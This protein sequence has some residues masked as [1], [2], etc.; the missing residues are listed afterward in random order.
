[1]KDFFYA[2]S[3]FGFGYSLFFHLSYW[4]AY[5]YGFEYYVVYHGLGGVAFLVGWLVL[6]F[7]KKSRISKVLSLLSFVIFVS[8]SV[9]ILYAM[10][11]FL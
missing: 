9:A 7:R 8:S 2:I 4:G 11:H 5:G 10:Q 3:I 1:M 6:V